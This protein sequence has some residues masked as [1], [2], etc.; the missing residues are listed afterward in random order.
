MAEPGAWSNGSARRKHSHH[1]KA[2]S[3]ALGRENEEAVQNEVS[4]F[5]QEVAGLASVT[6]Q[7]MRHG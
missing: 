6:E 7:L 5:V 1:K 2:H 3:E 4:R